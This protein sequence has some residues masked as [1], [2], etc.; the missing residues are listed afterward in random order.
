MEREL[1]LEVVRKDHQEA[2]GVRA[3]GKSRH[4]FFPL[5]AQIPWARLPVR[6]PAEQG[7]HVAKPGFEGGG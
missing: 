7:L 3:R 6:V 2:E 5:I 1:Q 4:R